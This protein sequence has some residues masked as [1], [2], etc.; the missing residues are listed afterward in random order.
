MEAALAGSAENRPDHGTET[1]AG[2]DG[3]GQRPR[4]EQ[5]PGTEGRVCTAILDLLASSADGTD[6]SQN[7]IANL[8]QQRK[9]LVDERKR[10]TK[11]L[12]N[13]TR[14][15]KRMLNKSARLSTTDLVEVL[16]IRQN[17]AVAKA[18]AAAGS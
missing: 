1:A 3:S 15:R 16:Q 13:E 7:S 8:Q 2:S 14:K 4:D 18:K 9:T 12:K 17:R 5:Q 6:P 11:Q 10:L